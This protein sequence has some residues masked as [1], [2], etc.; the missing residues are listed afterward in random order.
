MEPIIEAWRKVLVVE[1]IDLQ[2]RYGRG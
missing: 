2:V 1:E